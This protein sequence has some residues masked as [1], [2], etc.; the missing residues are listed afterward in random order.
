[1]LHEEPRPPRRLNDAVPRDVETI[2]LKAMTKEPDR[3]YPTA[4]EFAADLR[5]FL[6]GAPARARPVG[7]LSRL[8]R[9][10]RRNPGVA[11]LATAL[12]VALAGEAAGV[13]WQWSRAVAERD[14]ARRQREQARVDFRRARAAVDGYLTD[15]SD[16][17]D[18]K[19]RP[20]EPLR[21][22]L[23]QKA[24]DYYER[25]V[26][27]HPD[28]PELTAELAAAYGRLGDI[29]GQLE[30]DPRSVP[31]YQEEQELYRRLLQ[32]HPGRPDYRFELGRSCRALA[33]AQYFAGQTPAAGEGLRE[34]RAIE[35]ELVRERPDDAED[36]CQLLKT[37]NNMGRVYQIVGRRDEAEEAYRAGRAAYDRWA[38]GHAPEPRHDALL[39][40]LLANLSTL[41]GQTGRPGPQ[42]E[43][44]AEAVA[45]G[46][47]L[48]RTDP[49]NVEGRRALRE[50][51]FGAA[52]YHHGR[53]EHAAAVAALDR[54]RAV[55]EG[56]VRDHPG[57]PLHHA[58]LAT[59][60]GQ[61]GRLRL[62][63]GHVAESRA[64]YE[65]ALAIHEHLV[66]DFPDDHTLW[67]GLAAS[68]GDLA[69]LLAANGDARAALDLCTRLIASA[70]Q[71]FPPARQTGAIRVYLGRFY[72][73]KGRGLAD[74]DRPDEAVRALD[75]AL[76]LAG[77]DARPPV[78]SLRDYA[79][80][81]RLVA[82][83]NHAAATDRWR[84][85]A[86]AAPRDAETA[87]R[88]AAVFAR[89]AAAARRDGNLPPDARRQL[90]ADYAA[91][92]VRYLGVAGNLG[93]WKRS[94]RL[95]GLKTDPAYAALRER[96]DFRRLLADLGAAP[97]SP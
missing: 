19:A 47:R 50:A 73:E 28:D 5:R 69:R 46:E 55:A 70:E 9:W 32:E 77:A 52:Q 35:E 81:L 68:Y 4:A 58:A 25:F 87:V 85:R 39:A 22:K 72:L 13:V 16:D 3:R 7:R 42:G 49:G 8:W 23:L 56:L 30:S 86:A 6:N 12:A 95:A 29:V 74:L 37:L 63:Q 20:L 92:A 84:D 61:L 33:T 59:L 75:R 82:G 71:Q 79:E 57:N 97:A 78:Q 36:A 60:W 94:D 18:L 17:P 64:A 93:W 43:A 65:T 26:A 14:E 83:G 66:R 88:A 38:G 24:R 31:Y 80:A 10:C 53:G 15:V 91:A 34:A 21:R 41:Y 2:C 67:A 48:A 62:A 27:E 11:S 44:L 76:E 45:V 54:A 90:A 51:L 96:D 40:L 89:A 1:V